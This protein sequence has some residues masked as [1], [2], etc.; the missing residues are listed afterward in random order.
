LK[1][2]WQHK[3][4]SCNNVSSFLSVLNFQDQNITNLWSINLS[5]FGIL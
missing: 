5:D 1:S 3:Q 4:A 2:L